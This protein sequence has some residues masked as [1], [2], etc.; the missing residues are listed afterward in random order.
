MLN[1]QVQ[2]SVATMINHPKVTFFLEDSL[3]KQAEAGNHNFLKLV[4]EVLQESRF[5]VSYAHPDQADARDG[6]HALFHMQHPDRSNGVTVRR[7]YYY[8]FWQIERTSER[9]NWDVA[10]ASFDPSDVDPKTAR[11]F[12]RFWQKRL[13]KDAPSTTSKAGFVYVPLQGKLLSQRS[14]QTHSPLDMVRHVLAQDRER[15]VI[16]TLHPGEHYVPKEL[17]ALKRLEQKE[18]RLSLRM[19]EMDALLPHCDYIVTE[20]SSVA[21]AGYFFKKPSILFAG[22]D[23]HHIA[24]KVSDLGVEGAFQRVLDVKPNYPF[25]VWWFLQHQSINGGRPDAKDRI[26]QRLIDLGWPV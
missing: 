24:N 10:R 4:S 18:P 26:R 11:Q 21:F 2:L 1:I 20:N 6:S 19:G 23:F 25:Y 13:F 14:F 22:I 17:N 16:A 3:R 15:D 9:W 8:P 7:S 5:Q 12:Y